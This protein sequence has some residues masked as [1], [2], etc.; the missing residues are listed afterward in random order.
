MNREDAWMLLLWI[1]GAGLAHLLLPVLRL[2]GGC[3]DVE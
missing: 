2:A 3:A 1:A